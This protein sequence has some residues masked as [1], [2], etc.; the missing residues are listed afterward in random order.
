MTSTPRFTGQFAR[1]LLVLAACAGA[2]SA[3]AQQA[4]EASIEKLVAVN[5][6][7][8]SL[9]QA[10]AGME[11]QI[12]Q[13][14][15]SDMLKYNAGKPLSASQRMAIDQAVPGVT[16]VLHERLDWQAL[17]PAY[18]RIYKSQLDQSEVNRLIK[19]Y[20]DPQYVRIV[21]KMQRVNQQSTKLMLEQLPA[22]MQS[23]QPVLESA[24]QNAL[25]K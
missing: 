10:M 20:Q 12:R 3:M 8:K 13:Q 9:E 11:A 5:G 25:Q 2:T 19:L 1:A 16:Q 7:Q 22:I 6:A 14:I 23:L 21:E 17:K 18:I 24:V 4:S 15:L